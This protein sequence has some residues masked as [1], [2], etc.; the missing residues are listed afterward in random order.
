MFEK[1]KEGLI[2]QLINGVG[3]LR[4]RQLKVGID[5]KVG[6]IFFTSEIILF[7]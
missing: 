7:T 5:L 2:S 3:S 6:G 1:A 4:N